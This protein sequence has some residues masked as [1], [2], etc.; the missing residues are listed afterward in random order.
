MA[1]PSSSENLPSHFAPARRP[2][3][4]H[5]RDGGA[6]KDGTLTAHEGRLTVTILQRPVTEFS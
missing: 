5:E 6:A 2:R 4:Q 3:H 1:W